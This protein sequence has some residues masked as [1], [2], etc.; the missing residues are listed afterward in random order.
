[1]GQTVIQVPSSEQVEKTPNRAVLLAA[2][3]WL[4]TQPFEEQAPAQKH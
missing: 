4:M 3:R 2:L 1:M